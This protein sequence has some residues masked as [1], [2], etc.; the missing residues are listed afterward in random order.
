MSLITR[1]PACE[2]MFRVESGQLRA[3][4]GWVRCGRCQEAFNAPAHLINLPN[5]TEAQTPVPS[6]AMTP[7]AQAKSDGQ[8][9]EP[10]LMTMQTEAE[11]VFLD[12]ESR[13]S[14]WLH[15]PRVRMALLAASWLLGCALVLQVLVHERDQIL[16]QAPGIRQALETACQALRCPAPL[17][18]QIESVALDGAAFNKL[19][20][21][22]YQL[23]FTLRNTARMDL[24]LP[25]LELTLTDSRDEPLM[26]RVLR[27]RELQLGARALR[28][29]AELNGKLVLD[30]EFPAPSSG[31]AGY[32]L[33]A[34]YP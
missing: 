33:A 20:D 24:A 23:N 25:A 31:P 8:E 9:Q 28:A 13:P 18:R 30:I 6:A 4:E 3:A 29:G 7:P 2:T 5:V 26:R 21:R 19:E 32:R 14:G 17:A 15:R 34:F 22:L 1:C 12:V 27:P 10:V 11:G 16:A